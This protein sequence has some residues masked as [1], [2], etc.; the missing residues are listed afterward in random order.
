MRVCE[1]GQKHCQH[2][3]ETRGR[4]HDGDQLGLCERCWLQ[5]LHRMDMCTDRLAVLQLPRVVRGAQSAACHHASLY[6]AAVGSLIGCSCCAFRFWAIASHVS[7]K[8]S[9]R[10][11][12]LRSGSNRA[13]VAVT[14]RLRRTFC[15]ISA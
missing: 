14:A 13:T 2:E 10:R 12:L 1:R 9:A 15:A 5:R 4:R 3:R 7:R 11:I 6:A 8:T